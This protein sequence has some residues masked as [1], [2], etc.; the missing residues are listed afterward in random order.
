MGRIFANWWVVSALIALLAIV[1]LAIGAPIVVP[2]LGALWIR[3]AIVVAVLAVWGAVSLARVMNARAASDAIAA[4]LAGDGADEEGKILAGRMTDALKSLRENAGG[5]RDYLYSRPWYVIIGPPGAGKTTALVNSGLRFPVSTD[6]FKG[7]G[8][9]RNL[10]FLFSEQAVLVDTAGRYTS[11]DSDA[12]VDA[13]GWSEFLGLL[14]ANRPKQPI[15]GVIVAIGV[16]ELMRGDR[17]TID[18]HADAVRRRLAEVKK[19]LG[20]GI[21]IYVLLT[22]SD[23]IAG[24]VEYHDDLD[25]EGRRAVLGHTLP[26]ADGPTASQRLV[27]AFDELARAISA[28]QARRLSAEADAQ[29][30]ALILG[31]PSQIGA[32]R[33]RLVRFLERA[34]AGD[35]PVGV[36]RGF[37]LTSGM[38]EGTP[39][40]RM[41]S[42]MADVYDQPR[43]K[44]A[45]AGR[46]YFLNRLLG[47]V[48]FPEAGLVQ[49]NPAARAKRR[50][51]LIA[52]LGAIAVVTIIGAV[53]IIL[54]ARS[55]VA[56]ATPVAAVSQESGS[57]T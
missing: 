19:G 55:L 7:V 15:N 52:A 16:D 42:G 21:P 4:S 8:G 47:D 31:F 53:L 37:Y 50:T 9:T 40:D 44:V 14:K 39:L 34:F 26:Y 23:L 28:R 20:V 43:Q 33:S 45:G 46:A 38:Q 3:G 32:L 51:Q 22:K 12:A 54:N 17:A 25:V 56:A 13:R 27:D 30:R 10:D 6:Q 2:A 18:G 35:E 49:S 57:D 36:L 41:M 11:Q 1:V 5:Q 29:R 48:M 24:F